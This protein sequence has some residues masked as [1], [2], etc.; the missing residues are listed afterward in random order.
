MIKDMMAGYGDRAG[1]AQREGAAWEAE[2]SLTN[3]Q[4]RLE[5][6]EQRRAQH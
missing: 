2:D 4:L 3:Q 1:D 6:I 5:H